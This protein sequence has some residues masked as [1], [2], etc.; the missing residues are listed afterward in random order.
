MKFPD[1]I[2]DV[3]VAVVPV[4]S[5]VTCNPPPEDT[6][7][8]LLCFVSDDGEAEYVEK[9]LEKRGW[10]YCTHEDG[11]AYD[12]MDAEFSAYR[13]AVFG[14][15]FKSWNAIVTCDEKFFDNFLKAT[16]EC[17]KANVMTK[18][19]RIEVFSKY[20]PHKKPAPAA[21]G[22][23]KW[24]EQQLAQMKAEQAAMV[25]PQPQNNWNPPVYHNHYLAAKANAQNVAVQQALAA[26][27]DNMPGQWFPVAGAKVVQW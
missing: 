5:R 17:K 23:G 12:K 25:A 7:Q 15:P 9:W 27:P 3:C 22:K 20:I 4:G 18:E 11:K 19:G 6:D 1:N 13:K 8:D 21:I 10:T 16:K 2:E 26:H 14:M 24:L